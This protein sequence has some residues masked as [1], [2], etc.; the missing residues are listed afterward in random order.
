[1][2]FTRQCVC[3]VAR[4]SADQISIVGHHLLLWSNA[5][6][7]HE[8]H[9]APSAVPGPARK[10]ARK[11]TGADETAGDV[12]DAVAKKSR[13]GQA[14]A[15]KRGGKSVAPS[16]PQQIALDEGDSDSGSALSGRPLATRVNAAG[17]VQPADRNA[18]GHTVND[19]DACQA[20]QR[21]GMGTAGDV[22]AAVGVP[23]SPSTA[24]RRGGGGNTVEATLTAASP[25]S[26]DVGERR[27]VA[28]VSVP[29]V[30]DGTQVAALGLVNKQCSLT[31]S[32]NSPW[33]VSAMPSLSPCDGGDVVVPQTP[34]SQVRPNAV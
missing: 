31:P 34:D 13:K 14:A 16:R 4:V 33:V 25:S 22:H 8:R 5:V 3:L 9:H 1:M 29:A 10:K 32:Y 23:K 19:M 12:H 15:S 28:D 7:G 18:D 24:C 6:P 26:H 30:A 21:V 27:A 17:S 11:D 2:H 20:A